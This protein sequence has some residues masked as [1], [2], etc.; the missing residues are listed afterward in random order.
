M[1]CAYI[2]LGSNLCDPLRQLRTAVC[3]L[4]SLP[5]T[6]L[7]RVSSVYRSAAIGPGSQPEY[8]NAVTLVDTALPP[9]TLL[10]ALQHIEHQQHRVRG[11]RWGPRTIDLDL[12]LYGDLAMDSPRLTVPHPRMTERHFVLYPLHEVSSAQL[13]LPDGT[14]LATLLRRCPMTGLEKTQLQLV[15]STMRA[16]AKDLHDS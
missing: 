2:A 4:Q 15:D 3:A 9:L 7:C 6:Q 8:L 10:D 14:D 12:L 16:A 5:D 1:T 13:R 11:E